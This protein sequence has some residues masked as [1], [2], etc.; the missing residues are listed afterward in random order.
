[1][2]SVVDDILNVVAD[3]S[4][5]AVGDILGESRVPNIVDA[6]HIA[7]YHCVRKG[8]CSRLVAARFGKSRY[9]VNRI[10]STYYSRRTEQFY[11]W[12]ENVHSR[13]CEST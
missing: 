6:R 9:S 1:M 12:N 4:G 5:V 10:V 3:V 13:L 7:I 11:I 8:V 2:A